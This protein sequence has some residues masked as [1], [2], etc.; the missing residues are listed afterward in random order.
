M[1]FDVVGEAQWAEI[2]GALDVGD[3]MLRYVPLI[4]LQRPEPGRSRKWREDIRIPK[5][6]IKRPERLKLALAGGSGHERKVNQ[7]PHANGLVFETQK[8]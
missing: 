4:Y 6:I 1:H 2:E 5:A 8:F 3:G 7:A